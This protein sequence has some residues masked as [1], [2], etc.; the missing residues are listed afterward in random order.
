MSLSKETNHRDRTY[1]AR[2]LQRLEQDVLR[3]GT[4]VEE[5]FRLSHQSLFA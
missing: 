3:M 5:S 4:L 2:S 1:F